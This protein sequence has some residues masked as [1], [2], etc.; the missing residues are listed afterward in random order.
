[1]AGVTEEVSDCIT[2][3]GLSPAHKAF[4]MFFICLNLLLSKVN[5]NIDIISIHKELFTLF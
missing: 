4:D 1:M 2:A 5:T 3:G